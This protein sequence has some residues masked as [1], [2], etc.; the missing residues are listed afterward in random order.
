MLRKQT[1][2]PETN[3][4][5]QQTSIHDQPTSTCT[6]DGYQCLRF[7][8]PKLQ[9]G[10]Q[11]V[12]DIHKTKFAFASLSSEMKSQVANSNPLASNQEEPA[13]ANENQQKQQSTQK[14]KIDGQKYDTIMQKRFT[15]KVKNFKH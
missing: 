10:S 15:H 9:Q 6:D 8:L 14:K 11:A 4:V 5:R 3:D 13:Y 1:T 7:A 2:P 12:S